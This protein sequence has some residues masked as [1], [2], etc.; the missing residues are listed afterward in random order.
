VPLQ[1]HGEGL[2]AE[3]LKIFGHHRCPDPDLGRWSTSWT[4]VDHRGRR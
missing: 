1:Y 4:G 2:D 3:V